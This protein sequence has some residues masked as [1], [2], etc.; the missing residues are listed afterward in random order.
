MGTPYEQ[1]VVA[2]AREQAALLRAGK[3]TAIDIEH[4]AEEI[5]DVG[6]SEQ[7]ELASRMSVLLAH[8][9]KWQVQPERRGASWRTT[10]RIQRMAIERRLNK[11]PSMKPMLSDQDWI[12]D[13]W[14]D[15]RQQAANETGI[16]VAAFPETCPWPMTQVLDP[17]FYPE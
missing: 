16:G 2:W 15:A 5:E 8:L 17:E 12:S 11:T 9:L 4:I 1:D 14:G 6:K 7:R 13:M 10:L 3:L